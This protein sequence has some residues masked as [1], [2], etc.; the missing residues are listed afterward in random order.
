MVIIAL[1]R[2]CWAV[3]LEDLTARKEITWL[4][5]SLIFQP[6]L[7]TGRYT[8]GQVLG[9]LEGQR[10]SWMEAFQTPH[11]NFPYSQK[12]GTCTHILAVCFYFDLTQ[13]IVSDIRVLHFR[14]FIRK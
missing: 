3:E 7:F 14:Y 2:K 5:C 12:R 8:H 6:D 13:Q 9:A 10:E 4:R 1:A 11:T